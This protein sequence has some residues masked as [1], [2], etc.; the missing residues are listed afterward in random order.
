MK[1]AKTTFWEYSNLVIL[2][3]LLVIP[4]NAYDFSTN[5]L[6]TKWQISPDGFDW[7]LEGRALQEG[8]LSNWPVLRNP[9]MVFVSAFD[10]STGGTGLA[11][12]LINSA[13][14]ALQWCS[15]LLMLKI[16]RMSAKAIFFVTVSYFLLPIHFISSFILSDTFT[17]GLMMITAYLFLRAISDSKIYIFIAA[18]FISVLAGMFQFYGLAPLLV[19]T[20][21]MIILLIAKK[22]NT[23]FFIVSIVATVSSLVLYLVLRQL[24]VSTI[25]HG[26]VP[27][28]FELLSV[29]FNMFTFYSK[30]WLFLLAGLF[31]A[32]CI[33][34]F[35]RVQLR[36]YVQTIKQLP[37]SFMIIGG[38]AIGLVLFTFCYQWP[39]SR[40][41][42]TYIGF[43]FVLAAWLLHG[44]E[45]ESSSSIYAFRGLLVTSV[46]FG[47]VLSPLNFWGPQITQLN[48]FHPW[49][50][51]TQVVDPRFMQYQTVQSTY[52]ET[53]ND[54]NHN[55][56]V[57]E[58]IQKIPEL[59]PYE[60]TMAR[61]GFENCL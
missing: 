35:S 32:F 49:F 20:V 18:A 56:D 54:H 38:L 30:L 19:S 36:S 41:S 59:S 50:R 17:T 61:F 25:G 31:V 1:F 34:G 23:R 4:F 11:F 48:P 7:I 52:C 29:N 16:S 39:E 26:S 10:H 58:L 60:M 37:I 8:V 13:G 53:G 21:V 3:I 2:L 51:E 9:G 33:A 15:L 22:Q 44:T 14:L 42:Y 40:F 57:D 6:A 55:I 27:K 43:V 45:S 28:Q 12:A 5:V 46:L 47:I 24:W